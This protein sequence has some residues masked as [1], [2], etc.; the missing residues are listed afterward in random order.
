MVRSFFDPI[1]MVRNLVVRVRFWGH[2]ILHFSSRRRAKIYK[3]VLKPYCLSTF[4][5]FITVRLQA[6]YVVICC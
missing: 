4:R 5:A 3:K 6:Q 1:Y 2:E